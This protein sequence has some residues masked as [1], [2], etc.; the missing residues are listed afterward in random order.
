MTADLSTEADAGL[1][2]E[3]VSLARSWI[4]TPY[5]HQASLKGAGTDC[6][7][8]VRGLWRALYGAEPEAPPPYTPDWGET[9]GAETLMAA[10]GRWLR[11]LPLPA[12]RAGDV[13]L[14]R[15]RERGPAKHLG[16]VTTDRM[17]GGRIV[18]AY[19]GHGVRETHLTGS[20]TR[21]IA[22]AYRLPGRRT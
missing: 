17:D 19:S 3:A 15:M 18:H 20:W 4:G 7:G 11:P 6:L 1:R 10:A 16:L 9:D 8:L 22:G 2:A 5:C 21:R 13:L 14:F 12:V